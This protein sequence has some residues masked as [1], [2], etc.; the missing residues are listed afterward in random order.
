[1]W[2]IWWAPNN[3]SKWQMGFNSAFKG[4]TGTYNMG[5]GINI[6]YRNS[7]P[8]Q[9]PRGLMRRSTAAGLLRLWV[10]I[11]LGSWMFVCCECCVLSGS[12]LCDELIT[13]PEESYHLWC[14]VVFDRETSW[15]RRPWPTG[16]Y[17][18][19]NKQTNKTNN[20]TT[21]A[22]SVRRYVKLLTAI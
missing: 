21:E 6:K 5:E 14:V 1:M 10:R 20:N 22:H 9:W 8:S 19:K 11:P 15:M 3:A 13:R 12:S 7:T 17:R 4:L 16:G 2:R 18:A